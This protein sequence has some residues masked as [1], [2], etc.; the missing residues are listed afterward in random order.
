MHCTVL[1]F[2]LQ[3]NDIQAY[4]DKS[5][6]SQLHIRPYMAILVSSQLSC[7]GELQE[8]TIYS[9]FMLETY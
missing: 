2:K 6:H 5:H 7:H 4:T 9:S 1:V 3:F 8:D